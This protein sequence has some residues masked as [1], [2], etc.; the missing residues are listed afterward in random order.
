MKRA[1]FPRALVA[2]AVAAALLLW[3]PP[4]VAAA[5]PAKEGAAVARFALIVGVNQSVDPHMPLLRYADDDAV[6][7]EDLFRTLGGRTYLLARMDENTR[8]VSPEVVARAS[9]PVRQELTRVLSE[10][11]AQVKEARARGAETVFY[12]IYAGHGSVNGGQ[13]Y[14]ALEDAR[15]TG[16]D[17]ERDIVD[18]VHAGETHLIIDACYSYFL[19]FGRGPGGRRREVHGFAPVDGLARRADVGLLLSTTSARESHEWEGFQ[20]GVFS[21]EVRSG[22]FGAA[23]Y[24]GD[25]RVSYGEMAAFVDRANA[26]I[27]NERFRPDVF[28]RGP[29]RA[30]PLLDLRAPP[31]RRL[32]VDGADQAGRYSLEDTR[33]VRLVD[34]HN[35]RGH[36]VSLL[37]PAGAGLLYLRRAGD[38]REFEIPIETPGASAVISLADLPSREPR[39]VARGAA[40]DA[41][42]LIFSLPFDQEAFVPTSVGRTDLAATGDVVTPRPRWRTVAGVIA[43]GTAVASLAAA[44]GLTLSAHG[45]ANDAR[46]APSQK[47]AARLNGELAGRKTWAE[48]SYG[49]AAAA[50]VS[51]GLLMFWPRSDVYATGSADGELTMVKV[52]GQF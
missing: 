47:E 17:I 4:E 13:A 10:L 34:F 51:S 19:A 23:D 46:R 39:S 43:G 33:G 28:A 37:L 9:A 3:L 36:E 8:R 16:A 22:L 15:L 30:G 50:A 26:A 38:S 45:L 24:D 52:G 11:A 32:R 48:V 21:Y 42:S 6:R 40:H 20:A 2:P 5:V 41:F 18:K 7:Y 14:L 25:G 44:V 12:F 49:M 27:P 29:A 1:A 35:A 31:S